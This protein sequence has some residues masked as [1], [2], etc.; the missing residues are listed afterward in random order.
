MNVLSYMNLKVCTQGTLL[1]SI[2]LSLRIFSFD[3]TTANL[4]KYSIVCF[5]FRLPVSIGRLSSMRKKEYL[6]RQ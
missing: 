1:P 5:E 2:S 6:N 4:E 3:I